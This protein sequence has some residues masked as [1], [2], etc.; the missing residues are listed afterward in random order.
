[1][2][3]WSELVDLVNSH[4]L[5]WLVTLWVSQ[6]TVLLSVVL[7]EWMIWELICRLCISKQ[8]SNKKECCSCSL[9]GKFQMKDFWFTSMICWVQEKSQ[10][11]TLLKKKKWLSTIWSRNARLRKEMIIEILFGPISLKKWDKTFIWLFVS[12]LWDRVSEKEH[13]NSQLLWIVLLSIGSKIGQLKPC[14]VW[15]KI[16][17][18]ILKFLMMMLEKALLNLCLILS[19]WWTSWTNKCW[20]K[21]KELFSQLL[22]HSW[23]WFSCTLTCWL[24]RRTSW[25]NK[26]ITMKLVWLSYN[27][28][29]KMSKSSKKMSK[30]NKWL[31]KKR[32]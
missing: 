30:S 11:C 19:E 16:S 25:K 1:M 27:K 3:C 21:K 10:N 32:K 7:T 6:P 9:K 13:F 12:L 17:W 18:K 29:P 22:S 26:R 8:E 5:N 14:W 28:Q 23:N 24:T 2:L 4:W 15:L 31:L 20:N